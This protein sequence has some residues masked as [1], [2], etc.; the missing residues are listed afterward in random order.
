[1]FAFNFRNGFREGTVPKPRRSGATAPST[2][3]A[4]K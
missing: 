1:M 3:V 2:A 4:T